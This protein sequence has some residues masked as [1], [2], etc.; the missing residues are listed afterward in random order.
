LRSFCTPIPIEIRFDYAHIMMI[1]SFYL[2][3]SFPILYHLQTS[4][5]ITSVSSKLFLVSD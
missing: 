1:C 2:S 3:S 4:G 5:H